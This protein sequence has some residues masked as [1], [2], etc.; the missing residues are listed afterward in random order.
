[1]SKLLTFILPCLN[2]C[3]NLFRVEFLLFN[4]ELSDTFKDQCETLEVRPSDSA[5]G[6]GDLAGPFSLEG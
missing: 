6:D 4:R 2:S 3:F 1:M 5:C